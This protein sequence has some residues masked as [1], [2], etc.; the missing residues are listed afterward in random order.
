MADLKRT[1]L[2]SL[3]EGL[4][5]KV[6]DFCG[7]ELPVQ[8]SGIK[9]EHLAVRSRAGI[10]DVSHM[11]EIRV[12]GPRALDFIQRAATNDA[13]V[14]TDGYSQY[15]A[16]LN[17]KG[18]FIDDIFVYRLGTEDFL[19]CVNAANAAED[20][21]W[22]AGL[23]KPG[24]EV[25]D[26]SGEWAQI[27]VQGPAARDIVMDAA[28]TDLAGVKRFGVAR[29]TLAG[30]EVLAARTGYTGEDGFELFV[31]TENAV[32][33]WELIMQKGRGR[34]LL[35]VGLGAR[36]T[37]RLEM[38]YP[39]HG[40]DITPEITPVEADLEWI[41]GMKK[42]DFIGKN[43]LARQMEQGVARKRVG[44][45]MTDP[46]VPRDGYKIMSPGGEGIVTSGTK[47][48][49]VGKALGMGYV[50]INDSQN[51]VEIGVEIRDK[52]KKAVVSKWPFYK[53]A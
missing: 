32:D 24:C 46:G 50:P 38:G 30:T 12:R 53:K 45:I 42:P 29:A 20:Y 14:L 49:S 19:L 11:G 27:A 3:Y 33:A 34:G 6:V 39:L 4:G 36:D 31:P 23:E 51:G 2:F 1:P 22:L 8:F 7:W 43:V 21:K 25:R 48:P 13:S 26:E 41:V 52:I 17:E 37:L 16:L 15:S 44:F 35:P 10:F 5:G 28:E 9:D 40:H 18:G 47:P